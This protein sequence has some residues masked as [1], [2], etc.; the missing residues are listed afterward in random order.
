MKKQ[1][2]ELMQ[3]LKAQ[4]YIKYAVKVGTMDRKQMIDEIVYNDGQ[5]IKK[6]LEESPLAYYVTDN[7]F[8]TKAELLQQNWIRIDEVEASEDA[9]QQDGAAHYLAKYDGEEYKTNNGFF[10]YKVD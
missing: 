9:V 10:V 6:E 4:D 1:V 2:Q 5:R 7:A 3:Q 8:Y